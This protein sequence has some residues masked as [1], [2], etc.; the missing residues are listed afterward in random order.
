MSELLALQTPVWE[1]ML[2]AAV[3]Y[4]FLLSIFRLIGRHEF[5]QLSPFDLVLLLIISESVSSSLNVSDNSL[6]SGLILAA[7]LL[8]INVILSFAQY[9]NQSFKR[10]VSGEDDVK[11]GYIETEGSVSAITYDQDVVLR[12]RAAAQAEDSKNRL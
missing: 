2:R 12:R 8:G 1:L 10:I 11:I 5:G 9:K 7:T 4:F 3:I 6:T